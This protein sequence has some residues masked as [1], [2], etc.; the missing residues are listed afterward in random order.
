MRKTKFMIIT[1][2]FMF[3]TTTASICIDNKG[4]Y[5][6]HVWI[7]NMSDDDLKVSVENIDI[8]EEP[9]NVGDTYDASAII[10]MKVANNGKYDIELSNIDIYPYQGGKET[11]YF[12][13]TAKDN[14]TGFIGNIKSGEAKDVKIGVAL[15]NTDES[16]KLEMSNIEDKANEKV[17]TSIKIK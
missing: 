17:I 8:I 15:H 14:I 4:Y 12:V 1:L 6:K 2:L 10:T 13:S 5:G 9:I 7:N 3:C 11:K 16:I